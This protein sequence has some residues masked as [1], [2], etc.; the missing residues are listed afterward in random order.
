MR[1]IFAQADIEEKMELDE[2]RAVT[3]WIVIRELM[4]KYLDISI[5]L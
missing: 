3:N 2:V 1:R 5:Y 4:H